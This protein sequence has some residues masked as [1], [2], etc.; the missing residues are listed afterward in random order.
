[1]DGF[2]SYTS[3][4]PSVAIAREESIFKIPGY[5]IIIK[6]PCSRYHFLWINLLTLLINS[7]DSALTG[8]PRVA[9]FALV[10]SPLL[11]LSHEIYTFQALKQLILRSSDVESLKHEV[12]VYNNKYLVSKS[13]Y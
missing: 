12:F 11:F 8:K 9:L 3:F 2:L 13:T 6:Y 5:L 1:V 10:T 7:A 4:K